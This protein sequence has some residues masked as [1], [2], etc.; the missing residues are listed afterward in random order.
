MEYIERIQAVTVSLLRA[1][2]VQSKRHVHKILNDNDIDH[3]SIPE[4]EDVLSPSSWEDGSAELT[5]CGEFSSVFPNIS[6]K[7]MHLGMR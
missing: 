4:L 6:P 7:E 1:L 5:D 3:N 2:N